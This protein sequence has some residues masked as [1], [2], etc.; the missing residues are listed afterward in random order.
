MRSYVLG[1]LRVVENVCRKEARVNL[2]GS[3]IDYILCF[4]VIT[5]TL[6]SVL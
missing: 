5:F 2:L 3:L 1:E 4:R 6:V